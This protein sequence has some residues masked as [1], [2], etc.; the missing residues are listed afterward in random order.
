VLIDLSDAVAVFFFSH[1]IAGRTVLSTNT[2][3]A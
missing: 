1:A 2:G 3:F